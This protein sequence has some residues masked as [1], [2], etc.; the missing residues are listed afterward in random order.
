MMALHLDRR[1]FTRARRL[2]RASHKMRLEIPSKC[3]SIMISFC[4]VVEHVFRHLFLMDDDAS[5]VQARVLSFTGGVV[6]GQSVS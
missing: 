1:G 2:K 6:L 5:D 4:R 3:F